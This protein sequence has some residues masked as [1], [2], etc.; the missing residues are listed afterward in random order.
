[1][2]GFT[3]L[4]IGLGVAAQVAGT[5]ISASA[6]SRMA[7]EQ[8]QASVAAENARR[9]QMQLD[10]SR[11]RR[12]AIRQ[13]LF[14]RSAALTTGT[15]QGAGQGSG[16]QGA[17]GQAVATGRQNVNTVNSAETLGGRVFDANIQ[18]ADA[19]ARGQQ[20]MNF[21]SAISSLGGALVSNAGAIGRLGT[22]ATSPRY[23]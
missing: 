3:A 17:I 11:R 6:Q 14:A 23:A 10:A 15:N 5:V 1:M 22:Y 13:M 21:G 18:Y 7:E 8:R 20:G 4:A 19:T 9:Q 2:A 16:V 12:E